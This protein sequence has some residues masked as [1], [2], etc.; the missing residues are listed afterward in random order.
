VQ[1]EDTVKN[2]SHC[3]NGHRLYYGYTSW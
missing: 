3:H 2:S 1:T